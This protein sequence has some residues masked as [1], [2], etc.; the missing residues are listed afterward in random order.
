MNKI[1]LRR[2]K[3]N[4]SNK[5]IKIL[6][7]LIISLFLLMGTG[8]AILSTRLD[9]NGSAKIVAEESTCDLNIKTTHSQKGTWGDNETGN[10]VYDFVIDVTNNDSDS[11][12]GWE[13]KIKGPSDI[14]ISWVNAEYSIDNGILTLSN[15]FWNST[16]ESGM[17]SSFEVAITTIESADNVDDILDY[18][19]F[20]G[21]TVY[22]KGGSDIDE[23]DPTVELKSL[24]ISPSEYTMTIGETAPL[25]VIKTPSNAEATFTW[26]S[27]NES[28]VSVTSDGVITALSNGTAIITVSSGSI[29]ATSTIT[30]SGL[31]ALSLS[32]SEYTMKVGDTYTLT[33][34]KTPTNAEATLTWS[35]SDSSIVSVTDSGLITALKEGSATITVSSDGINATSTITVTSNETP[36]SDGLDIKFSSPYYYERDIQFKFVITNN[37]DSQI[38]NLSFDIGVPDGTI[39]SLWSNPGVTVVG[40]TF[41]V[42]LQWVTLNPGNTVEIT[43]NLTLPEGYT[44]SD[45]LNPTITNIKIK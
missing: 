8:Y 27:N 14:G 9:I 40:N 12:I 17:T 31:T 29:S 5:K 21:C 25:Q 23:P 28:V 16:I 45:Y 1:K 34:T 4:L 10:T 15:L 13:I 38:N 11:I 44:A 36:S 20:N 7:I 19:T 33:V 6:L 2:L 41:D 39:Y 26:T 24:Q 37:T 42:S 18:I 30:V 22:K 3:K 32:P 35:S 43:G